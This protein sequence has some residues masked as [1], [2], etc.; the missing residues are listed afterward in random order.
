MLILIYIYIYVDYTK[1]ITTLWDGFTYV[2]QKRE[3]FQ[4]GLYTLQEVLEPITEEQKGYLTVT[5]AAQGASADS[6]MDIM[7]FTRPGK[8]LHNYGTSPFFYG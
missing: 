2:T 5:W 4:P 3:P 7:W 8:R 1:G 6:Q